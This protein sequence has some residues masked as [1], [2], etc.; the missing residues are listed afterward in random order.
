MRC[1]E[2][3]GLLLRIH[4]SVSLT[5]YHHLHKTMKSFIPL[6]HTLSIAALLIASTQ[7]AIITS[8]G[9]DTTTGAA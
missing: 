3:G 6:S 9:V 7:A 8:L 1:G 5:N 2:F 4:L